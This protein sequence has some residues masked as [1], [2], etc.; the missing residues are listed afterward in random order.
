MAE[1]ESGGNELLGALLA[2]QA[3]ADERP[4]RNVPLHVAALEAASD[5]LP[6]GTVAV[7]VAGPESPLHPILREPPADP[8]ELVDL[9][10][11]AHEAFL[12]ALAAAAEASPGAAPAHIV[13]VH[14]GRRIL[15]APIAL[16]AGDAYGDV[17]PYTGGALEDDLFELVDHPANDGSPRP[18][19]LV[20]VHSPQLTEV[21]RRALA[22]VPADTQEMMISSQPMLI[23]TTAAAVG[24]VTQ[25]A[26][27]EAARRAL[28]EAARNAARQRARGG[29]FSALAGKAEP[30]AMPPLPSE[31]TVEDLLR[32]RRELLERGLEP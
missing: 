13:T 15:G 26:F 31:P 7:L 20:I 22:L 18:A 14:L 27:R 32:R 11:E 4:Q 25:Q 21:E 10:R 17:F 12:E 28:Q 6:A 29:F 3:A 1:R 23:P 24:F 8:G 2:L 16:R 19:G 30:T 9:A 5:T